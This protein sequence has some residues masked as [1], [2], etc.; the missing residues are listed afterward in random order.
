MAEPTPEPVCRPVEFRADPQWRTIDLV[1]D[2]H[3]TP[4]MPRTFARWREYLLGT[5]ADAVLMLGDLFEVWVGDDARLNGFEARCLQVLREAAATRSLAF[6]PGNRD[7]LV[8]DAL[9]RDA[10]VARLADPTLLVAVGQRLLLTHGDA[11]C[12]DDHDYQRMREEVRSPRWQQRFLALPLA[13]RQ[14]QARLMRDASTM[15]QAGRAPHQIAEVD[16]DAASRWLVAAATDVMVHGHT[17]RPGRH[18]L[19]GGGTRH[20]LG[21]WDLDGPVPRARALRLTRAGLAGLDL[22]AGGWS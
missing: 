7:F 12:L 19:A 21:D 17:H 22:A 1:S 6:M 13:E 10:G 11:L 5:A 18:V 8:G 3:L 16:A 4:A 14:R 2:L 9:L 20:V 15:H